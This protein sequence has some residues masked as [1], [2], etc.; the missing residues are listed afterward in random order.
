MQNRIYQ[1]K[2]E[3]YGMKEGLVWDNVAWKASKNYHLNR[4]VALHKG[5]EHIKLINRWSD[6]SKSARILKTDL[7]EDAF[8]QD[9]FMDYL[10][11]KFGE[12]HGIDISPVVV[13]HAKRRYPDLQSDVADAKDLPFKPCYFDLIISNST[14]DNMP[15]EDAIV[16]L[17]EMK[18][19]LK[20]DSELFITLD[21]AENIVY[22][23]FYDISN[24]FGIAYFPQFKCYSTREAIKLLE[25]SGYSIIDVDYIVHVPTPL[26]KFLNLAVNFPGFESNRRISRIFDC[27]SNSKYKKRTGWFIALRAI[28]N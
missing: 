11:L 25:S 10:T 13:A 22:K 27:L 4:I 3:M 7:F 26:N 28:K 16:A 21:N 9:S 1:L 17:E 12:V 6:V 20:Q 24:F 14:L 15:K 18:R 2:N 19:V 23:L 8:G 5:A